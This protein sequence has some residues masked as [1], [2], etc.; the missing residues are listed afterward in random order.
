MSKV[1]GS[2]VH[3]SIIRS[4]AVAVFVGIAWSVTTASAQAAPAAEWPS[5]SLGLRQVTP[6]GPYD[7]RCILAQ[8]NPICANGPWVEV[9][10][11]P[12]NPLPS[13]PADNLSDPSNPLSPENP[14]N[15]QT[16]STPRTR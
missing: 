5:S 13:G 8:G 4:A 12:Q 6:S 16:R 1:T 2:R 9:P 15:P 10:N 7:P 11:A 14:S 3:D